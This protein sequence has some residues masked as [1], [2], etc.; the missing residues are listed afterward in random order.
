MED[1]IMPQAKFTSAYTGQQVESAIKKA[2]PLESFEH[3]S[4]E[5]I[6]GKVFHVLWKI[7]PTTSNQVSGFTVHPETGRICEVFS[8]Q[9]VF[10]LNRYMTEGDYISTSEIDASF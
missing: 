5:V 1:N 7:T 2:L 6:N 9:K 3:V 4:D 8:N 10:S